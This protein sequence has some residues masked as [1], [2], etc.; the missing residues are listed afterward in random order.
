MCVAQLARHAGAGVIGT[1]AR[2]FSMFCERKRPTRLLT[3][4]RTF[5]T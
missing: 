3:Y 4:E 2:S 1:V 5:G